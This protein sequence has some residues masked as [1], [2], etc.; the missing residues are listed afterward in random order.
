M[1]NQKDLVYS[2]VINR[3]H[4]SVALLFNEKNRLDAKKDKIN[5]IEGFI[6][7]YPNIFAHVKQEDLA[8]FF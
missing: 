8:N 4:D 5:F 2:L 3:W 1:K 7:S 6:G